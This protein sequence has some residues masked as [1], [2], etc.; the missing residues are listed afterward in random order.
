MSVCLSLSLLVSE[1]LGIP[2]CDR[3]RLLHRQMHSI[4][5]SYLRVSWSALVDVS[6]QEQRFYNKSITSCTFSFLAYVQHLFT[7]TSYY[8]YYLLRLLHQLFTPNNRFSSPHKA[9]IMVTC[10]D[11]RINFRI[12]VMFSPMF[13]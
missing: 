9:S 8:I 5:L 10:I 7:S 1:W 12:T 11:G 2:R 13:V 6:V 3:Q 4:N